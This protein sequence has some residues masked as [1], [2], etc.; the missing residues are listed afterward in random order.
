[1]ILYELVGGST[2]RTPTEFS[3]KRNMFKFKGPRG[4]KISCILDDL[5]AE[6]GLTMQT[7]VAITTP[8][9]LTKL[10][11]DTQIKP[12]KLR[13]VVFDEADL[14]LETTKEDDLKRLFQ[15]TCTEEKKKKNKHSSTS[16]S[17][18]SDDEEDEV[19]EDDYLDHSR[20]YSRL[21]YLVGASLTESIQQI[22]P[23]REHVLQKDFTYLATA[24]SFA[25]LVLETPDS[26]TVVPRSTYSSSSTI[27]DAETASLSQLKLHLDPGLIH[28]RVIAPNNTRLLCLTRLLRREL[29]QYSQLS[30]TST[31]TTTTTTTTVAD[32]A[33][34][35]IVQRKKQIS[36][37]RVV[38]FFPDEEEAKACMP[39]LRDAMW[40]DYKLCVLLPNTGV[41]PLTVME[42]FKLNKTSVMLATANSVRG[43]D[44]EG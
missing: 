41:S 44:F 25:P 9:Y 7:D 19:E 17:S 8:H 27:H 30:N 24:T 15:R 6:S 21:T 37:P 43:L 12:E 29:Q 34:P 3:G 36:S 1:M 26:T 5:E 23:V 38:I 22:P 31:T 14:A 2:K 28:E 10:L 33:D 40:G 18:T 20:T 16:S 11:N 39:K 35:G 13:V 4:V 42:D 32:T